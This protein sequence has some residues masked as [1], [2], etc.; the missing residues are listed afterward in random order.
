MPT[1]DG[2]FTK[3]EMDAVLAKQKENLD[4][5]AKK[6]ADTQASG[7]RK[8]AEAEAEKKIQAAR[9]EARKEILEK[10]DLPG[11][12]ETK[13]LS[14]HAQLKL[15]LETQESALAE[16]QKKLELQ[17]LESARQTQL[18]ALTNAG[19]PS[20][21]VQAAQKLFELEKIN[22]SDMTLEKFLEVTS[23]LTAGADKGKIPGGYGTQA[24][25]LPVKTRE[26]LVQEARENSRI[27]F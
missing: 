3:E 25:K 2:H 22:N 8:A 4:A 27:T 20:D 17:A 26:Q 10:L 5:E 23:W 21:R 24:V 16:M 7:A 13:K 15:K 18:I 6:L 12:D 1:A 19:V 11:D 9:E 14:A